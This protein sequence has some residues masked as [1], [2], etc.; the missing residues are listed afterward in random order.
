MDPF[1][2]AE[3]VSD[4]RISKDAVIETVAEAVLTAGKPVTVIDETDTVVGALHAS[5]IINILFGSHSGDQT[6]N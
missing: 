1:D 4:L 5:K 3:D 6:N 2:A